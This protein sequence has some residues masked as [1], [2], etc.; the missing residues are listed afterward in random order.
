[1]N[2]GTLFRR[3]ARPYPCEPTFAAEAVQPVVK[4]THQRHHDTRD[5]GLSARG[6]V[7]GLAP[8]GTL[9]DAQKSV[10]LVSVTVVCGCR[11]SINRVSKVSRTERDASSASARMRQSSASE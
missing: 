7:A 3:P 11:R 1:M 4:P 5:K 9:S 8:R 10:G 6:S 2:E